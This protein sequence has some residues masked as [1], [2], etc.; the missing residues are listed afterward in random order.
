MAG[1]AETA[2]GARAT[3]RLPMTLSVAREHGHLVIRQQV[4]TFRYVL[5]IPLLLLGLALLAAAMSAVVTAIGGGVEAMLVASLGAFWLL[6]FAALTAPLGWWLTLVRRSIVV[7]AGG[8]H[9]V[10]R[11]DWRLGR[12]ETRRP[13]AAFRAVR[14]AVEALDDSPTSRGPTTWVQC[15]RLLAKPGVSEPSFA[16][17]ILDLEART[18]AVAAAGQIAGAVSLPLEVADPDARLQSPEREAN[19]REI[20][21]DAAR[22]D[23]A[24]D[25]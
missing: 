15:I 20:D 13:A 7:E 1:R 9:L 24:D 4:P 10:E 18:A 5:G 25:V 11:L 19:D 2:P 3:V 22:D 17:G 8:Q 16:L 14:V 12:R 6:L 23:A 21:E